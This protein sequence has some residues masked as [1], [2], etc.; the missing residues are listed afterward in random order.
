MLLQLLSV[1]T[2]VANAAPP[3]ANVYHGRLNQ[4]AVEIPRLR[5]DIDVDGR[6]TEAAWRDAA[7]S[8]ERALRI[9]PDCPLCEWRLLLIARWRQAK[10]DPA[11]LDALVAQSDKFTE[12]LLSLI[13]ASAAPRHTR[14]TTAATPANHPH[15]GNKE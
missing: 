15:P 2:A 11:R 14:K 13:P 12:P 4:L 7:T 6:L 8:Y 10:V 9:E 3:P 5:D 1:L